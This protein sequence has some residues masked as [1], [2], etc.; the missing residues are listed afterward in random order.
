MVMPVNVGA[1]A[2]RLLATWESHF[3]TLG[4]SETGRSALSAFPEALRGSLL[5]A[6]NDL[7]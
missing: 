3:D 6:P 5:V 1:D 4:E 2:D 7:D